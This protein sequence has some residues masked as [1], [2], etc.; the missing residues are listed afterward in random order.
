MPS[1]Q[2]LEREEKSSLKR[3]SQYSNQEVYTDGKKTR[4][5]LIENIKIGPA[6]RRIISSRGTLKSEGKYHIVNM[7]PISIYCALYERHPWELKAQVHLK[8]EMCFP[9]GRHLSKMIWKHFSGFPF[10]RHTHTQF[11]VRNQKYTKKEKNSLFHLKQILFVQFP[12]L[13]YHLMLNTSLEKRNH[14]TYSKH[15]QH[16]W[17]IFLCCTIYF[18]CKMMRMVGK[19]YF[20]F[21]RVLDAKK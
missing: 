2:P 5:L 1:H 6:R 8:R 13:K 15:L 18:L 4:F 11:S 20:S 12:I 14:I 3:V 21:Q 17:I 19:A 7:G 16:H 10:R 9:A